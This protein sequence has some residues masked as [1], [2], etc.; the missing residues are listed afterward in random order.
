[1]LKL[2]GVEY[3]NVLVLTYKAETEKHD[4]IAAYIAD[5]INLVPQNKY[6]TD[7][8]KDLLFSDSENKHFDRSGDEIAADIIKKYGLN[9][10][11]S[12]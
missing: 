10:D 4:Y 1:M 7:S 12:A 5:S 2:L 9:I 3:I 11:E 8:L 6:R